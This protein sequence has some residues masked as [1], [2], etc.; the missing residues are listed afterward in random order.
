MKTGQT[1]SARDSA[2]APDPELNIVLEVLF[3]YALQRVNSAEDAE[4]LVQ[5]ALAAHYAAPERFRKDSGLMTYLTGILRHKILDYYRSRSREITPGE[6]VLRDMQDVSPRPQSHERI[7]LIDALSFAL[8]CLKSPYR[9]VFVMREIDD[10]ATED[11]CKIMAI[12]PT[13]M[14]VIL[15]RARASLRQKLREMGIQNANI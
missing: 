2:R 13:N 3:A 8:T 7:E 6:E 15:F 14:N 4:D 5:S 12:S 9:E 1:A 10:L 11:V